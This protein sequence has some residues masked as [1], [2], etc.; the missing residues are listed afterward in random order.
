M[1]LSLPL[2][3]AAL[4]LAAPAR[5][6]PHPLAFLANE[7]LANTST[8][9][10]GVPGY[11]FASVPGWMKLPNGER[12]GNTHGGVVVDKN[13]Q[14]Y[15]TSDAKFS[16]LVYQPDGS[17]VRSFPEEFKGM[18]SMTIRQEQGE[19][20]IYAAHLARSRVVKLRLDGTLVW[21]IGLPTESG[22]YQNPGQYK[23]TGV[24]VGPNGHVY[25]ADG[26]GQNWIHQYDENQKY[27]RSFGGRGKEPGQFQTCHGIALDTR[28]AQPLLLVCDRENRRLQHFDLDGKFVK[29]V[30]EN[31]RRP[32]SVAIH[33]Q[34]L[35]VAELEARVAIFNGDNELVTVLGDNP[36]RGQWAKNPVPPD[37]WREGI[38]TAPHG[39]AFDAVGNLFV[40]DWNAS[41]RITLL[42]KL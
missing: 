25:I 19:E 2:A 29:V 24:A 33:G 20:Y 39:C 21:E 34:T 41:G 7:S 8:L 35:A 15:I 42:K 5:A 11:K 9:E 30:A 27:V 40:Q 13:G 10:M 38:F 16:I 37:Q 22:K 4:A 36:D 28:P 18:H 26:Y 31:L 1:R 12:V 17:Y 32:C 14:V 6:H 3:L 23:P